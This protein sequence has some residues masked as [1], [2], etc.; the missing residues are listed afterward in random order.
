MSK[1]TTT[2]QFKHEEEQYLSHPDE[3][4]IVTHL[5]RAVVTTYRISDYQLFEITEQWIGVDVPSESRS[6][7]FRKV[8]ALDQGKLFADLQ[9]IALRNL[10]EGD[11]I[12][13]NLPD[14]PEFDREKKTKFETAIRETAECVSTHGA[15]SILGNNPLHKYC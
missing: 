5:V 11:Y 6:Y 12:K 3:Q 8:R 1:I 10:S 7:H 9:E 2:V 15:H 14:Q 4:C 13:T